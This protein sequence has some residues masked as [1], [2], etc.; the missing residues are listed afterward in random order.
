[1]PVAF[2]CNCGTRWFSPPEIACPRCGPTVACRPDP[3]VW[4][5][6]QVPGT[7][8]FLSG[9]MRDDD[10]FGELVSSGIE[11]FVDVAGGAPYVWRPDEGAVRS[12]G[13]RYLRIDGVEDINTDLPDFAFDAAAEALEEARHGVQALFFC[14]AGLKRSPHLLFGVLRSWGYDATRAWDAVVSARPFVDP[15]DPYLASAERWLS[16]RN[17]CG[18]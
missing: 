9:Q 8:I 5:I 2:D 15:W 14:A 6:G 12:L 17:G 16:A 13:V 7:S 1:M 4:S 11:L 10:R 3:I 18:A